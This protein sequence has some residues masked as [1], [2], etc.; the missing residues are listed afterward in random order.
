MKIVAEA[1][2]TQKHAFDSEAWRAERD[3]RLAE[4]VGDPDAVRFIVQFAD[5][6][7][8]FD[9]LWD[10]DKPVTKDDLS[11]IL[12]A[13]L[14]EMPLNP[15]FDRFKGNLVPLLITGINAWLDAN[16][17]EQGTRNERVFAYVLRDWYM[18][19]VSFVIYLTRGREFMRAVSLDVRHFFT[20]H[21]TLE[22]YLEGL[23]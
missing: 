1:V 4:W 6:C 20:H 5:V 12:F 10:K 14:T 21:E 17:L 3:R 11:R 13:L 19:F 22:Q 7:E 2:Q 16:A 9:D 18:E 15:F 8:V 23:A